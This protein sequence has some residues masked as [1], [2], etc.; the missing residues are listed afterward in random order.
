ML[1]FL[2]INGI[3]EQKRD[4]TDLKPDKITA[5]LNTALVNVT[6]TYSVMA[7]AA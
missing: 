6:A 2:T 5:T 7:T 1:H 3:L 4:L